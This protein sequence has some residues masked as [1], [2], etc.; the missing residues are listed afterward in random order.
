MNY[1]GT[2][3]G[4]ILKDVTHTI[5]GGAP[6][7]QYSVPFLQGMVNRMLTSYHK[8][9]HV[10]I[11]IQNGVDC[12]ESAFQRWR[13]YVKTGNTEYLMDVANYAMMEFMHPTVEGAHYDPASRSPGRT[14]TS[15]RITDKHSEDL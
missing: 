6:A 10:K 11:A 8:Y 9:G 3:K 13:E 2:T 7:S 4:G 5:R 12:R 15:G 1:S 14:L